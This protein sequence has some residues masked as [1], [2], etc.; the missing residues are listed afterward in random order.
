M[1]ATQEYGGE[2]QRKK[3]RKEQD[4]QRPRK[5]YCGGKATM[6]PIC[7]DVSVNYIKN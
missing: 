2:I 5:N 4:R 3:Q 7:V 1:K 6:H